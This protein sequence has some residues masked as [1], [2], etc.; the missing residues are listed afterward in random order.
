MIFDPSPFPLGGILPGG[1]PVVDSNNNNGCPQCPTKAPGLGNNPTVIW[2][3][4]AF[5][6][7]MMVTR[8]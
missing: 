7:G 3:A 1:A 8:K 2:L 6:I 4:I 5:A